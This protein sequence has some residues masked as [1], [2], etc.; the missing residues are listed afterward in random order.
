MTQVTTDNDIIKLF[1]SK[2]AMKLDAKD[3][4]WRANTILMLDGAKY[5]TQ[6]SVR[7]HMNAL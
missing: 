4:N 3:S 7:Q 2:L 6:E 1:L 5:H